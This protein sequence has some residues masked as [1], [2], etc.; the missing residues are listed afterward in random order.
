MYLYPR[1]RTFIVHRIE[2]EAD[3]ETMI[4]KL[5]FSTGASVVAPESIAYVDATAIY[6]DPQYSEVIVRMQGN[7]TDLASYTPQSLW[8]TLDK[9]IQDAL[10]NHRIIDATSL[11]T[12]KSVS[13]EY[14]WLHWKPSTTQSQGEDPFAY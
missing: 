7:N 14:T 5:K 9:A 4:V 13:R 3:G 11:A 12:F 1:N 2:I 10:G 6:Y 8:E